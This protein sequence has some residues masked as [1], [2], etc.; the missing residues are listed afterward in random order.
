MTVALT[1]GLNFVTPML[2]G[3]L[4][5][6]KAVDL[7]S[8]LIKVGNKLFARKPDN[9]IWLNPM[10]LL[11]PRNLPRETKHMSV[12][13]ARGVL[14]I[15]P[16]TPARMVSVDRM[17]E[18][19]AHVAVRTMDAAKI[20]IMLAKSIKKAFEGGQIVPTLTLEQQAFLASRG[21]EIDSAEAG[22]Y[23]DN[24]GMSGM[25][26]LYRTVNP[27]SRGAPMERVIP[28]PSLYKRSEDGT[29]LFPRV[30]AT[31]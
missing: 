4:E 1:A 10:D 29:V 23:H 27:S 18:T 15:H 28:A 16:A 3:L 25:L 21:E 31:C 24:D 11:R 6:T 30:L 20:E 12:E 8:S 9:A 5:G 2:S 17:K 22:V 26:T 13:A 7:A 14:R 19:D